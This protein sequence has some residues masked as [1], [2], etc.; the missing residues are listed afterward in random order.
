MVPWWFFIPSISG[1]PNNPS[2]Y[3]NRMVPATMQPPIWPPFSYRQKEWQSGQIIYVTDGRQRDHFEQL[4]L[5]AGKWFEAEKE[6]SPALSHVWFGTILGEDNKAIK[7][8]D[9]QPIKLIDLTGRSDPAGSGDGQAKNPNL[10]RRRS[11]PQIACDWT[12]CCE[13]CRSYPRTARS[14]MYF[15]G[16]KC[17]PC[18]ATPPPTCNMQLPEPIVSF[19]RLN[20]TG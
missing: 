2:S 6:T 5:T 12:G 14:I 4:F 20:A 7:T 16:I 9:G 3:A 17:W 15:P 13:I 11:E 10:G 1:L 8:R 19:A 18:R